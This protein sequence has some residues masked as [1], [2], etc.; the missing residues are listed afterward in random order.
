M[1]A[2]KGAG[3]GMDRRCKDMLYFVNFLLEDIFGNLC[4]ERQVE[5]REVKGLKYMLKW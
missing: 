2:G 5:A 1:Q 3:Q 4:I